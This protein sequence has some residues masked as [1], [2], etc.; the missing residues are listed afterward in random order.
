MLRLS[1]SQAIPPETARVARA[2]F[3]KGSPYLVLRDEL[4]T[5]FQDE[6][7]VDLYPRRGQPALPPWRLA[8][9][10]LVQYRENLSDRQ[11][12]EAVRARIDI[13]YLLGMPLADAGFDFSVLCEFRARL[14]ESGSEAT[15][16][17]RLLQRCRELGLVRA[18]ERAR[19]DATRVLAAVRVMN[20]LELVAET[21]RAT[22]N[23]LARVAPAWL[24]KVAPAAWYE[25]YARRIE[26]SRLPGNKA[27]REAYAKTVGEDGYHLLD[28]APPGL[29]D[30]PAF[31]VLRRVWERH[32]SRDNDSGG[33]GAAGTRARLRPERE[34]AKAAEATESPY[35]P[36]ARYRSRFGV[37]WTG[38]LAHLTETCE[39]NEPHLITHVD[40]TAATV[41]EVRRVEAI[42]DALA[43]KDLLPGEHLA[44][45]AYIDAKLVVKVRE[46]HGVS[47]IGPPRRD[48]SWQ[49]RTAGGFT[50]EAFAIDWDNK[51]ACCP[52]GHESN[53]WREYEDDA[54]GAYVVAR[55]ATATCRACP[56][57]SRCTRSGK[58]G[59]SLHLHPRDAHEAIGAMR[60]RLASNAGREL[61]AL[62]AGVEGTI[63]QGVRAL[64]LR[65]ARYRGLERVHLQHVATAAAMNIDRV[66]NFLAGRPLE[67]TR[68][69]RFAA[70][71]A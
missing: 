65:R 17:D 56:L 15:L 19:T 54:R 10:T 47:M 12:A 34:L 62:R 66:T 67:R 21:L 44:D 23:E 7:F 5:V 71:R 20:R 53:S 52:Q 13:K 22:L 4:G 51:R 61:Y 64:G 36:D 28:A 26:D 69:S 38:Y 32:F 16:L 33:D 70:L 45:A 46:E 11:A 49:A 43:A 8:L 58:Q 31:A 59:R 1:D 63:S 3:P 39:A 18:G 41:H 14:R 60:E 2:A 9:V 25:R 42:H 37:E 57:R 48:A 30:L 35:D 6:D 68:T 29:A 50:N 55:F 24:R 40:T 27:A